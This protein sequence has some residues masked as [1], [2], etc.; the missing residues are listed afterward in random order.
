MEPPTA[1]AEAKAVSVIWR[2]QLMPI[3]AEQS[4]PPING[5]GWAKGLLGIKNK[6]T[7]DAPIDAT[8]IGEPETP[9][10]AWV[11]TAIKNIAQKQASKEIIFAFILS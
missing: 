8:M 2:A 9:M 3:N 4:C 6:I 10:S 11:I 7:S 5:Q 1:T